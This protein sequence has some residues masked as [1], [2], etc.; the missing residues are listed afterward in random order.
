MVL[1]KNSWHWKLYKLTYTHER[2]DRMPT[3]LCPYFWKIVLA[4]LL[5]PFNFL[6]TGPLKLLS[7]SGV[8]DEDIAT[9]SYFRL[10]WPSIGFNFLLCLVYAMI[11]MFWYIP[12]S[13]EA[14][15]TITFVIG[16]CCWFLSIISSIAFGIKYLVNLAAKRHRPYKPDKPNIIVEFIKAK[17]NKSCPMVVWENE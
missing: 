7:L 10:F 16:V 4:M 5:F 14:K 1:S 8:G 2:W 3:N 15:P 6:I 9:D 12:I 11:A 13:M 17:Y